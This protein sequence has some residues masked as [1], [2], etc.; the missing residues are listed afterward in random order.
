MAHI[1]LTPFGNFTVPA[2]CTGKLYDGTNSITIAPPEAFVQSLSFPQEATQQGKIIHLVEASP[3]QK[4]ACVPQ[5]FPGPCSLTWKGTVTLDY[6]GNY[7]QG[8]VP[9]LGPD[10]LPPLPSDDDL[11]IPIP[12]NA[13]LSAKK[14]TASVQVTCAAACSGTV[15]AYPASGRSA[16]KAAAKPLARAKFKARPGKLVTVKLRFKGAALRKVRKAK[17]LKLVVD[18]G[19]KK[20]TLTVRAR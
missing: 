2:T 19:G 14:G 4:A 3:A 16:H 12:T 7:G 20:K 17:K 10:D 5:Q 8:V 6:I 15:S 1:A 11:F 13:S 18:A 9:E